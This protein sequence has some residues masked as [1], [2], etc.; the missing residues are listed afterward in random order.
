MESTLPQTIALLSNTPAT[1]NAL[2]RTLPESLTHHNEGPGTWTATDV[3]LHLIHT[4]RVNWMPRTRMI[5]D[6]GET[7]TFTP[8]DREATLGMPN[9]PPLPQLLDE[10]ASLRSK[11]LSQL[12][13]LN[14]THEDLT[15]RGLHPSFGPVTLSQLL[16]AWAAHD[17]THLHQVSRIL[18]R[19]YRDAV[20]PYEKFL[21]VLRC[22]GHSSAA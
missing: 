12:A 4:E 7:R 14:L 17:L 22:E 11:S 19:Q 13:A 21:G 15:R 20:G 2:L 18:A 10:F 3:I 6:Y 16:S 9:I 8:L 5:L 1:F